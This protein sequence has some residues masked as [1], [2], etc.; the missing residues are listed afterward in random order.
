MDLDY[1]AIGKRIKISRI[2]AQDNLAN[3][4]GVS[5]SHMSNI[6]TGKHEYA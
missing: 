5:A 1:K 3:R 2:K 4:V 6:E